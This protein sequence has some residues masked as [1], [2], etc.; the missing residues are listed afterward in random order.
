M[1]RERERE[2]EKIVKKMYRERVKVRSEGIIVKNCLREIVKGRKGK[3]NS[4]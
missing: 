3:K 1:L 2:L 4:S